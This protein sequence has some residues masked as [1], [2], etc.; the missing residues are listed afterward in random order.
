L[1]VV[2]Y[3]VGD[4]TRA[5]SRFRVWWVTPAH[6]AFDIGNEKNWKRADACVF[7]RA[8]DKRHY[9]L[10]KKARSAGKLVILD[11][12]DYHFYRHKWRRQMG[13]VKRM[14]RVA[15]CITTGNEDDRHEIIATLK[16]RCYVIPGAQRPSK[17]RR[18]HSNVAVPT[19]VW[20]GRENTMLATLGSIWPVLE[21]LSRDGVRFRVLIVNDT[22]NTYGL[23]LPGGNQVV[24]KKWRLNEVYPTI[25]KCDVGVCPQ[26]KQDDG[27]YHK[28]ENKF[29]TCQVCGVPCV[30][31]ARTKDWYDDLRRLLTDWRFR[32]R[33]GAKGPARAAKAVS[34]K[35]VS[36]RWYEVIEKELGALKH[37]G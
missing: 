25:A 1:K 26:V 12:T 34:P 13:A 18:K 37:G 23:T 20:V 35:V 21:R 5:S 9:E 15:H 10:A 27:R 17:Y 4:K 31:F 28:D 30:S 32:A 14:A 36:A 3:P 33:Q 11:I 6:G 24:G 16:K 7:Q 8:L 22:G 29:W 2:F 19:V